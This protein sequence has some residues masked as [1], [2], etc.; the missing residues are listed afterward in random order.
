MTNFF[1]NKPIE[2][3]FKMEADVNCLK[4]FMDL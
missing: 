4:K 1:I 3:K 2:P